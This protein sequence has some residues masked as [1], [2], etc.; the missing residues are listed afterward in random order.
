MGL[1]LADRNPYVGPRSFERED[2][3]IFFGRD[4]EV[5]ALLSLII[6]HREVLLYAQSGAGKTSLL[7]AGLIPRLEEEGFEALPVARVRGMLPAQANTSQAANP[8]VWNVLLS[9]GEGLPDAE[10]ALGGEVTLTQF[11]AQ[12]P[13]PLGKDGFPKPRAAI[14]DQF[15]ELFTFYSERWPDRE[16]FF[17]QLR[18]ALNAD[19][20]LRVVLVMR[21]DYIAQLDPY[22]DILPDRL[23]TRFR[24]ERLRRAEALQAIV[25]PASATGRRY[26]PGVAERLADDLLRIQVVNLLGK[27]ISAA[28]EFIEPV[29]WQVVCQELWARLGSKGDEITHQ[30]LDLYGDVSQA[31]RAFY[32]HCIRAEARNKG[33]EDRLRKW[34]EEELITQAETRGLA[35]LGPGQKGLLPKAVENLVNRHLLRREWRAGAAWYE[36]AHDRLIGPI[37]ASNHAWREKRLR[38]RLRWAAVLPAGLFIWLIAAFIISRSQRQQLQRQAATATA[39]AATAVAQAATG[40]LQAQQWAYEKATGTTDAERAA[41][42]T[43]TEEAR[44]AEAQDRA[45]QEQIAQNAARVADLE[46][47][48]TRMAELDLTATLLAH[49]LAATPTGT[50]TPAATLAPSFTPDLRATKAI[51]ATGTAI[52]AELATARAQLTRAPTAAAQLLTVRIS[53]PVARDTYVSAVE[54]AKSHAQEGRLRVSPIGARDGSFALLDFDLS[55]VPPGAQIA[56]ATLLLQAVDRS[57]ASPLQLAASAMGVP[58]DEAVAYAPTARVLSAGGAEAVLPAKLDRA[59]ALARID[60]TT[61]V[62]RWLS[63]E[64]KNNG[65]VVWAVPS[66]TSVTYAFASSEWAEGKQQKPA[67]EITYIAPPVQQYLAR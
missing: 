49:P 43:A 47:T 65:L 15:E 30:H 24:L 32:E 31:L 13:H 67:L 8:Y 7:S 28:G 39:Q 23:R 18:D 19:P 42:L 20:L 26:A 51:L 55:A 60:V 22:L 16:D 52:V 61:F 64:S 62:Q 50:G 29:Q 38:E 40:T 4:D 25:G 54:T 59:D 36:L 45:I 44:L 37:K 21:E 57:N 34:I 56:S 27:T 33:E 10:A 58:W 53:I 12:R 5:D 11:L 9:W 66:Q 46:R 14:F 17:V 6:A 48:A 2:R 3:G 41:Q 1:P 63:G 35:Y